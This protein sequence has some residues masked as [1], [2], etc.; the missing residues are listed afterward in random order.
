LELEEMV[1]ESSLHAGTE[2]DDDGGPAPSKGLRFARE[3]HGDDPKTA[4][5]MPKLPMTKSFVTKKHHEQSLKSRQEN[6]DFLESIVTE[7]EATARHSAT[8]FW[9]WEVVVLARLVAVTIVAVFVDDVFLQSYAALAIV[10]ASLIAHLTAHPYSDMAL[11]FAESMGLVTVLATQ[12]GS[13]LW[14]FSDSSLTVLDDTA[15]TIILI[16]M[17]VAV[18][19]VFAILLVLS[20]LG[21]ARLLSIPYCGTQC[22]RA[23]FKERDLRRR[24]LTAQ[25]RRAALR[26]A[27]AKATSGGDEPSAPGKGKRDAIRAVAIGGA[28]A[29]GAAGATAGWMSTFS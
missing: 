17:N 20:M 26:E 18:L 24:F 9:Y 3:D 13:L 25:F 16:I 5:R 8:T 19:V 2:Q 1:D 22:S 23:F 7:L 11:N 4:A 10:I 21:D 27:H 6:T 15:I 12:L 14:F 29:A 28:A